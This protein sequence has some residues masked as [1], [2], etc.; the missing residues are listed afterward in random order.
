[1]EESDMRE[2]ER[3]LAECQKLAPALTGQAGP[4]ELRVLESLPTQ[5][6]DYP[7]GKKPS[8]GMFDT[9]IR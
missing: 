4:P 8:I 1:M 9:R 7:A 6:R 2:Y 3:F 5:D